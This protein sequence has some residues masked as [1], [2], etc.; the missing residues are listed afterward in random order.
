MTFYEA[1]RVTLDEV[2]AALKA[3]E[4]CF[5]KLTVNATRAVYSLET[6]NSL[7]DGDIEN[8]LG[9]SSSNT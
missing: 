8:L 5:N 6:T 3:L 2:S 7:L 1:N 9:R 4:S